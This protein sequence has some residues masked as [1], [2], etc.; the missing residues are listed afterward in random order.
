VYFTGDVIDPLYE[1]RTGDHKRELFGALQSRVARALGPDPTALEAAGLPARAQE[2]LHALTRLRGT[3]VSLLPETVFVNVRGQGALTLLRDSAY[4]NVSSMFR[5]ENR[6]VPAEDSLTVVNGLLGAYPNV[7]LD[8]DP[9]DIPDLANAVSRLRDEADYRA[10][11]DR[12]GVRRTNPRF[13]AVSDEVLDK[14]RH[15]QPLAGGIFDYNRL[16]NR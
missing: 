5:D 4:T 6:R 13:W 10:L 15:L 1:Y 8:V 9:A 3:A 16:E 2:A 11:L 12:F 7:F 14:Q